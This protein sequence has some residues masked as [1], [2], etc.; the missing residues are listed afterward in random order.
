MTLPPSGDPISMGQMRTEFRNDNNPIKM[1]QLYRGGGLV[2]ST[3]EV[4]DAITSVSDSGYP[5]NGYGG[6]R[7]NYGNLNTWSGSVPAGGTKVYGYLINSQAWSTP[8]AN[9]IAAN[10][11]QYIDPPTNPN[12]I[13]YWSFN[14][15]TGTRTPSVTL[16]FSTSR[17]GTYYVWGHSLT[18]TTMAISGAS[19]GNVSATN[20]PNPTWT[21]FS[22]ITVNSD[23]RVVTF[24]ANCSGEHI[25]ADLMISTTNVKNDITLTVNTEV[26][27]G[28][29]G[30]TEFEFSD[31]YGA[32]A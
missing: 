16:T 6:D 30:D 8:I 20:L 21:N 17:L 15:Q 23:N 3:T 4:T 14:N 18:Y 22:T 10:P 11:T 5:W 7:Y 28:G 32:T 12:N 31:L 2:P 26:P 29:V 13:F 24:T 19:S 9:Y 27:T 1:S 25:Y